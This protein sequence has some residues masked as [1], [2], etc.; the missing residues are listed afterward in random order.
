MTRSQLIAILCCCAT[1]L[2]SC[3]HTQKAT[4]APPLKV[5][6]M[7]A[8]PSS[9]SMSRSYSGTIEESSGASLSFAA[10]GTIKQIYVNEGDKVSKGQLIASIDDSNLRHAHDIAQSTLNQA[11]DAYNRMKKLHEANALPDMQWVEIQNTLSQAQSAEAIAK[12]ALSDANLYASSSGY[13]SEKYMDAGMNVAP[14]IPIV[15]VVSIGDVKVNISVPENEIGG[16]HAGQDAIVTVS[17]I[18]DQPF[19]GKITERGVS[20]SALSRSYDVKITIPN[21]DAKLLPGMICEAKLSNDSLT[22][23]VVLPINT[24][25]L[26]ANNQNFIWI[27]KN[28]RAYKKIVKVQGMNDDGIVV[29]PID[30]QGDSIIYEGLQKVSHGT[31]IE[32]IK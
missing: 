27:A 13:V 17:A 3:S 19:N 1:M 16:I 4:V 9:M 8:Q 7:I 22:E 28:G 21:S 20:A 12:K 10:A 18:G 24:V 15:K 32:I 31:P 5:K 29:D 11:Q 26:D 25:L 14:G 23:A 30:V 2:C 6:A